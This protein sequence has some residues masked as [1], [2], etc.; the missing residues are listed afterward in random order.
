MN[1]AGTYQCSDECGGMPCFAKIP[2]EAMA[3]QPPIDNL[4]TGCKLEG[5]RQ[6]KGGEPLQQAIRLGFLCR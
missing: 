3:E 6:C 2:Q 5:Y 4:Y 1:L